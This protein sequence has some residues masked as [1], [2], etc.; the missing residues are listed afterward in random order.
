MTPAMPHGTKLV[1]SLVLALVALAVCAAS[2]A[3]AQSF[4]AQNVL[5]SDLVGTSGRTYTANVQYWDVAGQEA[6]LYT[7]SSSPSFIIFED[8]NAV[9]PTTLVASHSARH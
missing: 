7:V 3:H 9:R 2:G 8:F 1:R 5:V 6:I 4:Q